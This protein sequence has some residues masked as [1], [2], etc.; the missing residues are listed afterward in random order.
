MLNHLKQRLLIASS[1]EQMN[2]YIEIGK[3]KGFFV[4]QMEIG[5]RYGVKGIVML[6]ERL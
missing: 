2:E 6:F 5:E 1:L 3:E 4:K